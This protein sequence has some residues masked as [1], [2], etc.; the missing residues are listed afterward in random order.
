MATKI[1]RQQRL[2]QLSQKLA[3]MMPRYELADWYKEHF[4]KS[5]RT[6]D[7]D[8]K[9]VEQEWMKEAD[10]DSIQRDVAKYIK[11]LETQFLKQ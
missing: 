4:N 3:V 1:Q 2:R 5:P 10:T 9:L 7:R 6:L 8:V 11:V